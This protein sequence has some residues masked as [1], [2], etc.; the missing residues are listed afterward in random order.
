MT[1]TAALSPF[2]QDTLDRLKM[3]Y[4]QHN[5]GPVI[6]AAELRVKRTDLS[7][8]NNPDAYLIAKVRAVVNDSPASTVRTRHPANSDTPRE[9]PRGTF[10]PDGSWDKGATYESD[11]ETNL[12]HFAARVRD[13]FVPP[14]VA[15][16]WLMESSLEP[17]FPNLDIWQRLEDVTYWCAA[18]TATSAEEWVKRVA[19][20]QR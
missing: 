3:E 12:R 19:L 18:P 10:R 4:P 2:S 14:C 11:F 15:A 7:P 9:K 13:Q 17:A 20:G 6:H 8:I 1:I 5:L 16:A